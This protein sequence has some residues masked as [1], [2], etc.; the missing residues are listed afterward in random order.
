LGNSRKAGLGFDRHPDSTNSHAPQLPTRPSTSRFRRPANALLTKP[1]RR[2][3]RT[4]RRLNIG[5]LTTTLNLRGQHLSRVNGSPI[6]RRRHPPIPVMP[7]PHLCPAIREQH[8][9]PDEQPHR[10]RFYPR[11]HSEG[12]SPCPSWLRPRRW[13]WHPAIGFE[14]ATATHRLIV[15]HQPDAVTAIRGRE[16]PRGL[17]PGGASTSMICSRPATPPGSPR[18]QAARSG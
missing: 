12:R 7:H 14:P 13:R 2:R 10:H 11:R 6:Q 4:S 5:Y 16:L 1:G 3:R 17:T 9:I 8:P 18:R 15:S